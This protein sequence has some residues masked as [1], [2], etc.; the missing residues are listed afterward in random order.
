MNLVRS[1]ALLV[2]LT[3]QAATAREAI[4]VV[5]E[6]M[7]LTVDKPIQQIIAHYGLDEQ[8]ATLSKRAAAGFAFVSMCHGAAF[9]DAIAGIQLVMTADPDVPYQA[10]A[11]AMLGVYTR[12]TA[13]RH[14]TSAVC[15]KVYDDAMGKQ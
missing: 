11:I 5:P 14:Q 8:R 2:S 10:A 15:S 1:A 4:S 7:T 3:I 12:T 6:D 9:P 13:F